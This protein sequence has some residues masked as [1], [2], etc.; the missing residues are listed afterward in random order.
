MLP[1]GVAIRDTKA[2]FTACV[3]STAE[4]GIVLL[5]LIYQ[6]KTD[7]V[8]AQISDGEKDVRI[9]QVAALFFPLSSLYGLPGSPTQI[10]LP[11]RRHIPQIMWPIIG[12][13]ERRPHIFGRCQRP[14]LFDPGCSW[15]TLGRNYR[16]NDA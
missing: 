11:E 13:R 6:G 2:A 10:T 4:G 15:S 3:V 1:S 7:L 8:H 14:R 9:L 12:L 16:A 5:Q